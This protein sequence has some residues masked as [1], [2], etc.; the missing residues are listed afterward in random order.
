MISDPGHPVSDG[1]GGRDDDG[2]GP[3]GAAIS[4]DEAVMRMTN[5]TFREKSL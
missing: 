1:T 2:T 5:Q 3:E 4:D